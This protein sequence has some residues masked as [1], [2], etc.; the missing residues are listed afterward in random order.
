LLAAGLD[1]AADTLADG[2]PPVDGPALAD[3]DAVALGSSVGVGTGVSSP[4]VPSTSP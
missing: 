4:L 1:G 3:G 2:L